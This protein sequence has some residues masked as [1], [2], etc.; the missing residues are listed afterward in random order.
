MSSASCLLLS[1]F[2]HLAGE[3][4]G[5]TDSRTSLFRWVALVGQ[6]SLSVAE[7]QR[8]RLTNPWLPKVDRQQCL[9]LVTE[10]KVV[11]DYA[12]HLHRLIIE[13]GR[14]EARF[15]GCSLGRI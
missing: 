5:C 15:E 13:Q 9:F 7:S 4:R 11:S 1:A 2:S 3:V 6:T 14:R 12:R 10:D 8:A